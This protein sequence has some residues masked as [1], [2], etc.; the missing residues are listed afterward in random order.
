M[1]PMVIDVAVTPG[2]LAL[3]VPPDGLV[4]PEGLVPPDALVPAVVP[5]GALV[6]EVEPLEELPHAARAA[7]AAITAAAPRTECRILLPF[8]SPPTGRILLGRS[9]GGD[10]VHSKC[11]SPSPV[12]NRTEA[13]QGR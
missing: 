11:R 10:F 3:F 4:P 6:T 12:A 13:R 2:A 7:T 1:N 9:R 5:L 8:C